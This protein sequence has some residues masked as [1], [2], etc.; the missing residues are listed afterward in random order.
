[1][2]ENPDDQAMTGGFTRGQLR[3]IAERAATDP[4]VPDWVREVVPHMVGA[5]PPKHGM[6][7]VFGEDTW[8]RIEGLCA[9]TGDDVF[10]WVHRAIRER[11]DAQMSETF[12]SPGSS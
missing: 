3:Q 8:R 10:L 1:M 6:S 11:L 7:V 4:L 12:D 5:I 9:V 2:S